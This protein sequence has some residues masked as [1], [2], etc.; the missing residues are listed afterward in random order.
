MFPDEVCGSPRRAVVRAVRP[1]S[2]CASAARVAT[3]S[4]APPAACQRR[5]VHPKC[6]RSKRRRRSRRAPPQAASNTLLAQKRRVRLRKRTIPVRPRF[7]KRPSEEML[8]VV[9]DGSAWDSSASGCKAH[10]TRGLKEVTGDLK[11]VRHLTRISGGAPKPPLL[12][13]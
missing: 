11:S 7:R 9:Q 1:L 3:P 4:S 10:I 5:W 13:L 12:I 6:S 8:L 2:R